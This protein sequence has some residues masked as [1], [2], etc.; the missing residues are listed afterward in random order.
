IAPL[1]A[2]QEAVLTASLPVASPRPWSAEDPYLY[3]LLVTLRDARGEILE[4]ES[5]AVGFRQVEIKEGQLLIN[6]RPVKIKGV[7]RH[8]THPDLGYAVT[9]ESMIQDITLMKQHNINAVRTSH[10]PNDPR[11]LDL[12]D[13]YGLYVIDE[14]DLETHGFGL[15]GDVSRLSNDPAW[16]A[17]FLDRAERMVER[18]KNHPSVIIWSLGNESGYGPNHDAMAAWIRRADPT[19]PIHYEP[20]GASEVVDIVSVMYPTVDSLVEQGRKTDDP[21]PFFMCEYAHAMGN[22]PGN[23]KESWEAI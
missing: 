18:D 14:A 10:Y 21:R 20:A 22:G 8:E 7:N 12:C 2:G 11:W 16:Q 9:L 3:R 6:G 1:P 23:L 4:V 13:L 19:R 15:I 5:V 17:A